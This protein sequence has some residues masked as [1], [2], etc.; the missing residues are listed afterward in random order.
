L[1]RQHGLKIRQLF[2]WEEPLP[3]ISDERGKP[4]QDNKII[5]WYV[6]CF[7]K[8]YHWLDIGKRRIADFIKG[9]NVRKDRRYQET[10]GYNKYLTTNIKGFLHRLILN[11]LRSGVNQNGKDLPREGTHKTEDC[12]TA[13]GSMH[14]FGPLE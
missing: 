3:Y 8:A 11:R 5:I 1:D 7:E 12:S 14:S 9:L 10:K 2:S 13:I 4:G 6:Y